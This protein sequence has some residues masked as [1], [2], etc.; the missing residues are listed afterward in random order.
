MNQGGGEAADLA[1]RL[2]SEA[3]IFSAWG[4]M[5]SA[6]GEA[7]RNRF[8]TPLGLSAQGDFDSG[9]GG[10]QVEMGFPSAHDFDPGRNRFRPRVEAGRNRILEHRPQVEIACPIPAS[11]RNRFRPWAGPCWNGSL[12]PRPQCCILFYS[13]HD[14]H[15]IMLALLCFISCI[16]F[17]PIP[18]SDVD[19]HI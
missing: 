7:G 6:R 9:P 2:E 10:R 17:H 19:L 8:P 18:S 5:I 15:S 13:C 14:S 11:G 12:E 1:L 4:G 16:L 3:G